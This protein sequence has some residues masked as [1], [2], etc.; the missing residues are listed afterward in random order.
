MKFINLFNRDSLENEYIFNKKSIWKI[1][2]ENNTH[3]SKVWRDLRK[4]DIPVRSHSEAYELWAV[5][6]GCHFNKNRIPWNIGIP[7]PEETKRKMRENRT[8][9]TG[10]EHPMWGKFGSN[11]P[12]W[13]ENC[14]T[15]EHSR[16]R[17]SHECREW[18]K[19]VF[20]RDNYTCVRCL[21]KG[22][23]GEAICLHS[24]H[25]LEFALFPEERF[26]LSNGATLCE[27]CHK[28]VH[29]NEL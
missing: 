15:P 19:M 26:E 1:A 28:Y 13:R 12:A 29:L 25:I 5:T 17:Q 23:N 21:E 11:H 9:A 18:R 22:G 24:H 2:K 7:R 3:Y 10:E 20:E 4:F 16:I 14:V 8:Y 27:D 6:S